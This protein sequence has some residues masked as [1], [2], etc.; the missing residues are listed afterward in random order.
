MVLVVNLVRAPRAKT[1]FDNSFPKQGEFYSGVL[2]PLARWLVAL[3]SILIIGALTA[4][5]DIV[6]I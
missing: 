6:T 4:R 3:I 1:S 2:E 5:S